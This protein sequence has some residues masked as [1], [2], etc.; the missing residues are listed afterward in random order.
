MRLVAKS[1][2]LLITLGL[3]GLFLFH[4]INMLRSPM[5]IIL[6]ALSAA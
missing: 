1:F 4:V 5:A 6:K 3:F 2:I